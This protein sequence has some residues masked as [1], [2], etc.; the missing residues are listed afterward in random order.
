MKLHRWMCAALVLVLLGGAAAGAE[1]VDSHIQQVLDNASTCGEVSWEITHDSPRY[2][3]ILFRSVQE[4]GNGVHEMLWADTLARDGLYKGQEITLSQLLGLEQETDEHAG[5]AQELAYRLIW[6]I[7][8]MERSAP[9]T[10]YLE[11]ITEEMLREA[12]E[13][14]Q[15]F[16]LDADGNVV[17]FIQ[18]GQIASEVAGVLTFPFDPAEMLSAIEN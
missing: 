8:C 3:S 4:G 1:M 5:T 10:D 2:A 14:E 7:I 9:E 16:Y 17:F 18:P 6:Q 15:D 12:F 11:D 13:P